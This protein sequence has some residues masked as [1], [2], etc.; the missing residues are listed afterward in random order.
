MSEN[1][2]EQ[3]IPTP[4][5][6]GHFLLEKELG[7][8]G[9]GGVYLA[10]D[11]MLDRKVGIK[12]M[13]KSLGDDPEFVER[14]QREA[15]AAARLNH[16]NI[17]Q[18]YSFGT[19][20]GMPY[21]AM[22]LVSGGSL[23]KEMAANPGTMDPV[24]VMKI[25]YQMAEALALASEQGLVHGDVK[26]E[27]V[28]F[29]AD[30]NAK[31]VDFGL[32]A[33][34][35]D[36]DEIWGTPYYI[37]PE[38]VRRQKI[39]FR[40]DIYSL[41]GT[42]YHALTGVAPFEG[43]DAT[44][45]VKA[46][47][48]GPPKLPSELRT[49]LSK[50]VDGIIMRMLEMEPSMRYPT[51]QSLLGDL[52]RFLAKAGPQRTSRLASGK[53]KIK[54]AKLKI[55]T[56]SEATSETSGD[57]EGKSEAVPNRLRPLVEEKPKKATNV[58]AMV[59]LVVFLV[60]LAVVGTV[61]GL[62]WY[63]N[64]DKESK[65]KADIAM[66]VGKIA[67]ARTAIAGTMKSVTEYGANFHQLV[68]RNDKLMTDAARKMKEL[69]PNE[70]LP[71]A[72]ASLS[73]KPSK[74]IAD[75]IAYTNKLLSVAQPAEPAKQ[76]AAKKP[77]E[78]KDAAKKPEAKTE[79]AAEPAKQKAKPAAGNEANEEA[80]AEK[81]MA[82]QE[83]RISGKP[84]PAG[85]SKP[86]VEEPKKAEEPK[87]TEA[88]A[89]KAAEEAAAKNAEQAAIA[90]AAKA[91]EQLGLSGEEAQLVAKE[92]AAAVSKI[93]MPASVK[94]FGELWEGMFLARGADIRVQGHVEKIKR[95]AAKAETM[96]GE[97]FETAQELA[98]LSQELVEAFETMK[99]LKA[100][101]QA[102]RKMGQ[103]R[104]TVQ[105]LVSTS[106]LQILN[107]KA[108]IER[109][110][111]EAKERIEIAIKDGEKKKRLEAAKVEEPKAA[112]EKFQNLA[113]TRLK[114]QDWESALKQ[115]RP[116]RDIF[117]SQEGKDAV[118][119]QVKKVECMQSMQEQ[120][121]KFGKGFKFK[122]GSIIKAIDKKEI[123]IQKLKSVRGQME[124]D[125]VVKVEWERFYG[126]PDYIGYMNQLINTLVIRGREQ[127][128][129]GPLPWSNNMLGAALTLKH[130]YGK[131]IDGT[132]KMAAELV[133]KAVKEFE[134]C[135]KWAKKWF[136]EVEIEGE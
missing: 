26:P 85:A 27:N 2:N 5:D 33:M 43:E 76:D 115:L 124:P 60:I 20:Q 37:S 109:S 122:D 35:G 46:R 128:K 38:K 4:S 135:A 116:M 81:A 40:A 74:E 119:S 16:P 51:Y 31:L 94:K 19:E 11:K 73:P 6:F 23:D 95:I 79:K 113:E 68:M 42:L 45:V 93:Q 64:A 99:G 114:T 97:N 48:D 9:M 1:E 22:E 120:F 111:K 10:R 82:E 131:E 18:I 13:L 67:E 8:G 72:T 66:T 30:G 90:A 96:T 104:S 117:I 52:K 136:P 118:A 50:D 123:T 65:R 108:S 78:K 130:L 91:A 92:I 133:K 80:A 58:G 103:I 132:E 32:A 121:I 86:K 15:Q 89:S 75:A 47:F 57:G 110:A 24:R 112:E 70:L 29:D 34:Q 28:L 105:Q 101:D 127:T 12:V 21:I 69:L 62:I 3:L 87:K 129:I 39:D 59:G 25:G 14:F 55:K 36:S 83:A 77:E 56:Q 44:A 134:D 106:E 61:G 88:D 102:Q 54:N 98:A 84:A 63:V 71:L 107:L 53:L 17:A 41:G 7:H 100:V 126:K 125:K 49:D